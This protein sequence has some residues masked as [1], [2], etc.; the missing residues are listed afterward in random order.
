[1]SDLVPR[2]EVVNAPDEAVRLRREIAGLEKELEEAKAEA[3]TAKQA[4]VDG[5]A[6]IRA[7][8]KALDPTFTALKMIFGEISR[9]EANLTVEATEGAAPR[10][11]NSV[12]QERIAKSSPQQARVLQTLL[13]GGGQMSYNQIKTAAR[14]YNSTS[15]VLSQLMAKNWIHKVGHGNYAL[16]DL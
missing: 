3:T 4:A 14:T 15:A 1:M 7:L 5:I 12:W 16:K 10:G 6:A 11:N 13:D 9:V 8:R 2:G